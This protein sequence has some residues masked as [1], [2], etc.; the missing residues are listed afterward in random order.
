MEEKESQELE[1]QVA[2]INKIEEKESQEPAQQVTSTDKDKTKPKKDPGRVAAGKKL[3]EHN[4]KVREQKKVNDSQSSKQYKGLKPEPKPEL[5]VK[6]NPEQPSFSL[7][8]ILSV[9][10]IVVSLAGLYYKRKELMELINKSQP[11]PGPKPEPSQES[12]QEP[13]QTQWWKNQCA[14]QIPIRV[15]P[16][17]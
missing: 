7:T 6:Q 14:S 1:Q 8:Q 3:V 2:S 11:N 10:S 13:S 17:D 16:M 9:A 4:R 15:K 12:S 5:E